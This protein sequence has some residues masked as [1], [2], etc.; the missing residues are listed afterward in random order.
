MALVSRFLSIFWPQRILFAGV[1]LPRLR[2]P[3]IIVDAV[4]VALSLEV[5]VASC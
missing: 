4:D 5:V 1:A 2:V 3:E